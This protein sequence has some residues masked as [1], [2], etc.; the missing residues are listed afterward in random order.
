MKARRGSIP[1]LNTM[2]PPTGTRASIA[3]CAHAPRVLKNEDKPGYSFHAPGMKP[4][5]VSG[6]WGAGKS[7]EEL[8]KHLE[9]AGYESARPS[10]WDPAERI[11]DMEIDGVE[12]EVLYGTLGMRLFPMRDGRLQHA[13]FKAYND[14]SPSMRLRPKASARSGMVSLWDVEQ[15]SKSYGVAPSLASRAHDLGYHPPETS[16]HS[17]EYD[18]LWGAARKP[19]VAT[20]VAHRDRHG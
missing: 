20:V 13:F 17:K 12:A 10:G 16:Y 2:E 4:S 11:K 15:A 5:T 18:P 14:G 3:T 6:A 1:R 9:T 7:G 8:K 19:S